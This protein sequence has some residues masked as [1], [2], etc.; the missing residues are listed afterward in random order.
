M[1]DTNIRTELEE[2]ILVFYNYIKENT[3]I[4]TFDMHQILVNCFPQIFTIYNEKHDIILNLLYENR[5]QIVDMLN[6]LS[7]TSVLFNKIINELIIN[8]LTE[9]DTKMHTDFYEYVSD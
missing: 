5:K 1:I 4:K 6:T 3:D 2:H 9:Y 8:C 7:N